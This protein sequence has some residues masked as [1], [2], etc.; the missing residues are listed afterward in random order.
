[1]AD[2]ESKLKLKRKIWYKIISPKV[3]GSKEVGES[4]LSDPET[5]IG[6]VVKANLKDLTGNVRDQN[7][8]ALF[9]II[10]V[11]GT[12]LETETIGY[13]LT[14]AHIKR[15]VRKNALRMDDFYLAKT[16]DGKKIQIKTLMITLRKTQRS[17]TAKLRKVLGQALREEASKSDFDLFIANLV[18]GK[19]QF[20]IRKLLH[21]IY[22]LRELAIKSAGF[23]RLK[24]E[25]EVGN[26]AETETSE[27]EKIKKAQ[28]EKL[29]AKKSAE[30]E[31]MPV[32][33]SRDFGEEPAEEETAEAE[34]EEEA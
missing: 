7:A 24:K 21:K 15:L 16:Q 25:K 33:E 5:S 26:E 31:E 29:E 4:Y 17:R 12:N 10:K 19:I 32:P 2:K 11:S 14:P 9:K 22:P 27:L 20:S 28:A 13:E 1:M 6:R 18:S 8:Y 34:P 30:L 23:S 3:F